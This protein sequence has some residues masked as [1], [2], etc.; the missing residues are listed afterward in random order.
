MSDHIT[1]GFSLDHVHSYRDIGVTIPTDP[2]VFYPAKI[3]KKERLLGTNTVIDV[4]KLTSGV[5]PYEERQIKVTIN[6]ID[7][8]WITSKGTQSLADY[9]FNWLY[10]PSGPRR[11]DL[12]IIPTHYFIGEVEQSHD[13]E[14]NLL[15][16]GEAEVIFQC[17]P[18]R[19]SNHAVGDDVFKQFGLR[20][21]KRQNLK[22]S[23]LP[24][25]EQPLLKVH[26]VGSVVNLGG[27]MQSYYDTSETTGPLQKNQ[28]WTIKEQIVLPPLGGNDDFDDVGYRFVEDDDHSIRSRDIVQSFTPV[29]LSVWNPGVTYVSPSVRLTTDNTNAFY[30]GISIEKDGAVYPFQH[31]TSPSATPDVVDLTNPGFTLSPGEN[32]LK[33]YGVSHDV[34]MVFQ[35]MR[36]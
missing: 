21:G 10:E 2:Q 26:P 22:I 31:N 19:I 23:L 4:S 28:L 27:W 11:I 15:E 5:Q 14:T 8:T 18:F 7:E 20:G 25:S 9:V 12:D 29:E 6:I 16:F 35:E 36:L 33:I 17:Q 34:E 32:L 13:F 3:K 30:K 1:R 24:K